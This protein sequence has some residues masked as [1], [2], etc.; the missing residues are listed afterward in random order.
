MH[1]HIKDHHK[2]FNKLFISPTFNED[3]SPPLLLSPNFI[4]LLL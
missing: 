4:T 1:Q 2:V 3:V